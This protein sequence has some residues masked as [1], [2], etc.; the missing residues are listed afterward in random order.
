MT[1][2]PSGWVHST[3][4]QVCVYIRRGKSPKY[5]PASD[6]PVVNQKCV[7]WEGID[8]QH[9]KFVD[10]SQVSAWG[11]ER[12][13]RSGDILWNSTGTG[14][15]GRAAVFGGSK[16][17]SQMVADSH[18]TVV[19]PSRHVEGRFLHALV[20]SPLVQSKIE[21]MQ[22]GST[23]QVELS[24]EQ[25]LSTL[26]PLPPQEEQRRIVGKI[27]R[28]S[29][30]SKGARG[31]LDHVPKLIEKFKQAALES[32]FRDALAN[33][34]TRLGS[35]IR[36][37]PQNGLYLSKDHYGSGVP[38]LRIQNF[39]FERAEP[40]CNWRKVRIGT[41]VC[42]QY[43]LILGDLIINRVNSPSHL[44]KS[45]VVTEVEA[46]AVFESNMMRMSLS[47]EIEPNYLRLYL[48]SFAGRHS[49][50]K[51]A[52]WAVNQASINQTDV[53]ETEIPCPPV[54][55]QRVTLRT[56][57]NSFKWIDRV[58]SDATSARKLIDHLDQAVLSKAFRGE[59]VPQDP[60]DEPA[61]VLLER[62]KTEETGSPPVRR[63]RGRPRLAST[64]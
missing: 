32:A 54:S 16:T 25:V 45:F 37:G 8:E 12:Y 41:T 62:I 33:S 31:H 18:V 44:G 7:R 26:V 30:K 2:L 38:I 28:L 17:Y 59:L 10:P 52:K 64:T 57:L 58:A 20:S 51:N 55:E 15:I 1:S 5:A 42:E 6:L 53:L 29:A 21:D 61:S 13:L 34:R 35:I 48:N 23:N 27:D 3:L 50:T 19:R 39:D 4:E 36:S 49:L 43:G 14:T 63:G 22:S 9:L 60:D 11:L 24:R 56:I 40:I 46:G 47:S